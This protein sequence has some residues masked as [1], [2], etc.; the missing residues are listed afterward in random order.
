MKILIVDDEWR[1]C[2]SIKRCLMREGY[3]VDIARNGEEA[4]HLT[5]SEAYDLLLLDV[6]MPGL[7][8]IDVCRELRKLKVDI[9]I[10]I[11]SAKTET[12]DRVAGLDAGAD[13]YLNKPFDCS[14]LTAR[15][16]A[17]TRRHRITGN[18]KLQVGD[19][20]LNLLTHTVLRGAERIEFTSTEYALI[21]VLMRN[22]GATVSISDIKEYAW[23]QD[24]P[25]S[26]NIVR[27]YIN[28]VR[29]KI[30][31][32]RVEIKTV[33]GVGYKLVEH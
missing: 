30:A 3:E 9:P 26:P 31:D 2:R 11:L 28:R 20:E 15:V 22:A 16:R 27:V 7:S 23:P 17:N 4:L 13:D 25:G 24:Q 18:N 21:E 19:L 32:S 29:G 6:L 33:R 14:E 5:T 8:G 12:R 10:I 1:V